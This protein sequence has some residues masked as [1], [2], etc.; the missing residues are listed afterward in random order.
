LEARQA[1]AVPVDLLLLVDSSD[2]MAAQIGTRSKWQMVT[3]ALLAFLRDPR[4]AGLGVGLQ[5]F[6]QP[7]SGSPCR[8]DVDCGYVNSPTTPVCQLPQFCAGTATPDA[9]LKSCRAGSLSCSGGAACLPAGTCSVTALDCTNIG[10]PCPS[11]MTGDL[12][13]ALPKLCTVT[14]TQSCDPTVYAQLAAPIAAL[15][16]PAERLL[17]SALARRGPG[18]GTPLG[19]AVKGALVQLNTQVAGHP[20]HR[21]VLVLATDGQPS[22]NCA[23]SDIPTIAGLLSAARTGSRSIATYV[24]GIFTSGE[25]GAQQALTQLATAGGTAPPF[26]VNTMPD[27]AQRFLDALNQI[28]GQALPCEFNIP[29]PM[30]GP[31]DFGKVNVHLKLSSGEED[32]YYTGGPERC[33]PVRGGWYY[34]VNPAGGTPTRIVTCGASCRRI[35]SD[36][37][38][39]VELRF[40]CKTIDI[41]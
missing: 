16:V 30:S 8:T 19:A 7:G 34:D 40:G 33:D 11:G 35:Q 2:S 17:A 32:I 28:R 9:G 24:I 20:D 18:G 14:D 15:P 5:F 1:Q 36:P 12:C 29:K 22:P 21:G 25:T 4:S 27:L 38:G 39:S 41:R 13:T 26:V 37:M 3:E 10:Q 31:L 23:P 6:P